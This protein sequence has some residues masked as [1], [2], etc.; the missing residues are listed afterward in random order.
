MGTQRGRASST[1]SNAGSTKKR[2]ASLK[3]PEEGD[4]GWAS[5]HD[6]REGTTRHST[7]YTPYTREDKKG[8]MCYVRVSYTYPTIALSSTS[9]GVYS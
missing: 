8:L 9:Q 6:D 4:I 3:A 5:L 7:K 1:V 2:Q